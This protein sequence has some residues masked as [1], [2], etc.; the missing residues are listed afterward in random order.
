MNR[1]I[2][3]VCCFQNLPEVGF[4]GQ[5]GVADGRLPCL[6]I[7]FQT[8]NRG[9]SLQCFLHMRFAVLTHHALDMDDGAAGAFLLHG[10]DFFFLDAHAMPERL[11]MRCIMD[12]HTAETERIQAHAET[13]KRHRCR[14]PHGF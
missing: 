10:S 5:Q 12:V 11:V 1:S 14:R 13:G 4:P 8:G 9:E 6:G 3:I 2:C 7:G